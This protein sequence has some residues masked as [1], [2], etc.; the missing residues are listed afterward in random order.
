MALVSL[1]IAVLTLVD[2][3]E[4]GSS[5]SLLPILLENES[6]AQQENNIQRNDSEILSISFSDFEN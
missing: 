2:S 1:K 4:G 6:C 3:K 5:L